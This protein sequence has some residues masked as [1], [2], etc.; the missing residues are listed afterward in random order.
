MVIGLGG[1]GSFVVEALARSGVG[2][3]TIVDFDRVCVTNTNRQLQAL[4]TVVGK[5][6]ADLLAERVKQINPQVNVTC[7]PIFY[8]HKTAEHLL[9]HAPDIVVDAIDNVT[10]KCHLL[11][12]CVAR[13]I[14]VVCSTG[15]SGRMDPTKIEVADLARTT[16]D[17][18]A[19]AV[20]KILRQ[21]YNFPRKALFGIQAVFSTEKPI[22]PVELTYDKG[23]GFRCV[24]PG[25]K[26]EHHSCE[27]RSVIYGTASFVTGAFGLAAASIVTKMIVAEHIGNA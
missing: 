22:V 18:L 10:A 8:S 7:E 11:A 4:S 2:K 13:G 15:A 17:P 16:V 27:E 12:T 14:P 24:C 23:E 20:R 5:R 1:V 9:A 3:L 25:G 21:E 6:K 19:N 26:N